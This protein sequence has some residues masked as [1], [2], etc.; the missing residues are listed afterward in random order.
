MKLFGNILATAAAALALV[1]C[2]AI[3]GA[4][5]FSKEPAAPVMAAHN[6]ILITDATATEN[7]TFV[8]SKARFIDAAEYEYGLYVT[9]AEETVV[10][11]DGLAATN[12]TLSKEEFRTFMKSNFELV[13]NSTHTI[14]VYVSITDDS[15]KVYASAPVTLDVYVYDDAVASEVTAAETEIVLDKENPGGELELLTWTEARLAYGE[16]VTYKVVIKIGEGEEKELAAGIDGT[17]YATTVDALNEAVAAAGGMEEQS[18]DV[19]FIVYA[20]CESLPE[21]APSEAVKIAVTTYVANFPETLWVPGSHQGWTPQTAPVLKQSAVTKGLYQ[22]FL[23]LTDANGGAEVEFKFCPEPDWNCGEYG[24]NNVEV[25]EAGSDLKVNIVKSSSVA[26]ENTKA[27]SGFYYVKLDKKFGTLEMIQVKNLELIGSFAASNWGA[28]VSMVWD[29]AART[30]SSAEEVVLKTDDEI[31]VR[32]N[33]AWDHKFG[34]SFFAIGFGGENIKFSGAEGSYQVILDASSADFTMRAVNMASDYFI[35]GGATGWSDKDKI[36]PLYPVSATIFTFTSKFADVDNY[37]KAWASAEFGNWDCAYGYPSGDYE[38][39]TGS[40][41]QNG[42]AG[43]LRFPEADTYYTVTFDFGANTFT[44]TKCDN[45]TPA[46]Y[47]TIGVVGSFNG[48]SQNLDEYQM[49]QVEK[50][51]HNWYLLDF[52]IED[53]TEDSNTE[54]IKINANKAWDISWGGGK[55][56]DS[57]RFG[58]LTEGANCTITPGVYDIYFN[59]ITL[60]YIFIKK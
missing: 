13:Q 31:L 60:Q 26:G 18:N 27:P 20:C 1:S 15:G 3:E 44:Q 17:E 54:E 33:S 38:G 34:G 50:A 29:D 25:S 53:R 2:V 56:F 59:D 47:T 35:V 7:V 52:E 32:F 55:D 30:W 43:A 37:Y 8:W 19:L 9:C 23:D 58:T 21:G 4:D 14:S 5:T 22:G 16:D 57:S 42:S 40:L 6:N 11:A 12:Y 51:P 28:T 41:I 10:L 36:L 49:T 46:V 39:E 48:W 45:Q 24:F